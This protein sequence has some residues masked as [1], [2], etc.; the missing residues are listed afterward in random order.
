MRKIHAVPKAPLPETPPEKR[1]LGGKPNVKAK[2]PRTEIF[3]G[4]KPSKEVAASLRRVVRDHSYIAPRQSQ[5]T[6]D[7]PSKLHMFLWTVIIFG[8]I[9]AGLI[10]N[11]PKD[12]ES[13]PMKTYPL[14]PG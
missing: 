2:P 8:L 3:P 7:A 14:Q 13:K 12:I 9:V 11:R 10:L 4:T 5:Q 1:P 6:R